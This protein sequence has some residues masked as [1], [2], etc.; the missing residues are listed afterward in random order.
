VV[1]RAPSATTFAGT[2]CCAFTASTHPG[3]D[4]IAKFTA[5]GTLTVS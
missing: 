2:P 5:S 3:G 1:V 4:K